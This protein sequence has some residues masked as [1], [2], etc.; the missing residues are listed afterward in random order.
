LIDT[1]SDLCVFLHALRPTC[2]IAS[3]EALAESERELAR[4]A[5]EASIVFGGS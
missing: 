4:I 2:G 3:S 5:A 1:G